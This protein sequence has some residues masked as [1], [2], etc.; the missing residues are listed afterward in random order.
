[1]LIRKTDPATTTPVEMDGV[2]D[3]T[4][5][6]MVGRADGAPNFA[7]RHFVVRPGGHTPH[8]S[9]DYEHEVYII[10]GEGQAE[11][12]GETR[13]VQAGD[14]LYVPANAVHQFRNDSDADFRFLC[15]V[16]VTFDCDK[17]VPGS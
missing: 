14:M 4:M 7:S 5:Q 6:V 3:V 12:D 2:K 11:C 13:T 8:H 9:H 16:P 17:P 10:E 1:M 15:L